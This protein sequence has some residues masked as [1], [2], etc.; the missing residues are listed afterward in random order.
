[1]SEQIGI[2][3]GVHMFPIKSAQEAT[4]NGQLPAELTVGETGFVHDGFADRGIVIAGAD[5]LFASQRGWDNIDTEHEHKGYPKDSRL[6]TVAVDI[7]GDH[8]A[9][10][11]PGQGT[12]EIGKP[13]TSIPSEEVEMFGNPFY[14]FDMG[15]EVNGRFS[16]LLDREVRLF[17]VDETKPRI[18]GDENYHRSDAVNRA[19]GADGF[20]F[21][22]A[23]LASLRDAHDKAEVPQGTLPIAAYR[24]NVDM[25]TD[26]PWV[27]DKVRV[28][29]I[30]EFAGYV[31]K[32]CSR[33]PI[34][35]QDQTT[36]ETHGLS[37]KLLRSIRMGRRSDQDPISAK[38]K[39]H[40]GQNVNHRV[41]SVGS[42]VSEG[43]PIIVEE[44]G[45]PNFVQK[46]RD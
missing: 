8:L 27:E 37:N 7:R 41:A 46:I 21:L 36:G 6:A 20:P 30:E 22:I 31:V 3:S 38:A 4:I 39:I 17:W 18:I 19:A 14:G 42:V 5:M 12:L 29:R 10:T 11:I 24:A 2:V 43:D 26:Q 28:V 15:Q 9:V 25:D 40:F 16:K 32:A 1:M 35:N 44:W 13:D 34:P 33:C 23:N 45:E